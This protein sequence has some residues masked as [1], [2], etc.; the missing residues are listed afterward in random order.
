[1]KYVI[2]LLLINVFASSCVA[3]PP[4]MPTQDPAATANASPALRPSQTS[5][6]VPTPTASINFQPFGTV[7]IDAEEIAFDVNGDGR[8]VDSI[9]FWE[10]EGPEQSLMF[11]TSKDND[12]IE[13]YQYPFRA[14][15]QTLY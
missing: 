7:S 3:S 10:A 8:N 9:A 4:L 2:I 6:P 13:V 11:V 14:Q 15:L 5:S 12:S 1:M